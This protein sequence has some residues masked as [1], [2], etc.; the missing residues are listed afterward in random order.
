M[1]TLRPSGFFVLRTP[2]LPLDAYLEWSAGLRAPEADAADLEEALAADRALLV[3]R[4]RALAARPDVHD[5]LHLASPRLEAA[6]G[7]W[8]ESGADH[9]KLE[10]ALARYL[11]RMAGRA[12]PFGLFAGCSAGRLGAHARL[13]LDPR[14]DRSHARLGADYLVA[15]AGALGRD[16]ELRRELTYRP[17][18][19]RYEAAGRLRYVETGPSR[20]YH[21]VDVEPSEALTAVL[22]RARDGA[23]HRALA[24]SL[25]NGRTGVEEAAA[26]VDRL[27]DAQILVDDLTVAVTGE[28]A[29]H[30]LIR[31]LRGTRAGA[32]AAALLEGA[33]A[34]LAEADRA[35][36]GQRA[37]RA[38]ALRELLA[39]L[40]ARIDA[41][42]LVQVDLIR[43]A[44]G[45]ELP[46][47]VGEDLG[48][49]VGLLHRFARAGEPNEL[50]DLRRRFG[51]RYGDAAV[52]L[53]EA[54]DPE[55][56]LG[57]GDEGD[58]I[59]APAD[60]GAAD[61][62][63]ALLAR[64]ATS[65]AGR[66]G[67]VD[68][69]DWLDDVLALQPPAPLP[70]AL[71]A[72][73][74]L[75][76]ASAAALERGDYEL[77]LLGASGPSG[78]RLLG[79]FCH[80]DPELR[81]Q[82]ASHLREEEA[83]EP[84]AVFAEIAHLPEGRLGNIL[85]RPRLRE[86][87]IV[88]LAGSAAAPEQRI[89][90]ADLVLSLE[91]DLLV[92][93]SRRLG[94]RVLPRLTTAHNIFS[95]GLGL[96]R[97]LA[98][99]QLQHVTGG[100]AWDWG[101]MGGAE[102]LPRVRAGHVLLA[103]A[104][105]R[106]D[107]HRLPQLDA[108]TAAGRARAVRDWRGDLGV[109]RLVALE[110]GESSLPVDLENP[111]A[112]ELLLREA[113]AAG[114]AVVSEWWPEAGHNPV[115]GP[116]GRFVHEL[117]VPF[118]RARAVGAAPRQRPSL[119][120]VR[121]RRAA[122]GGEWLYVKLYTG[123]AGADRVLVEEVAPLAAAA[124][125]AGAASWHFVRYADPDVHLRVRVGGAREVLREAVLPRLLDLGERLVDSG[126]AWRV[127]HDTYEREVERYGGPAAIAAA[128]AA[129]RA[130]SDAVLA[131]LRAVSAGSDAA[132]A[133]RRLATA[134][135]AL[136]LRDLGL[137][138]E[139]ARAVAAASRDAL[140]AEPGAPA[141]GR[142]AL[143]RRLR[144]ERPALEAVLDAALGTGPAVDAGIAALRSRSQ[145]L[146]AVG[147]ELA[148]L[149]ARGALSAPLPVVAASLAHMHVNRLMRAD[150]R[151]HELYVHD[152]LERL[153]AG[154]RARARA[155][156]PA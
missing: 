149:D 100:I 84:D 95:R 82:V 147:R 119:E 5:A 148:A 129:F 3:E 50:T 92:L 20:S 63:D 155:V 74:V 40:P 112:V 78:A 52:P 151:R 93:R 53:T 80:A 130:D 96:Y 91:D 54:L 76:A 71:A 15:L 2:A 135:V 75:G 111:L 115:E 49:A 138:D 136:L 18:P 153:G 131:M 32:P 17:N 67:D 29:A 145:P 90:P 1:G 36:A 22:E 65:R 133:R 99:L 68:L 61:E 144:A 116:G 47:G 12:T 156:L 98:M 77:R 6:I 41:A 88:L 39:P 105:W 120:A 123:A 152:A 46:A 23:S 59:P 70:N 121:G 35:P 124:I 110:H 83:L 113:R 140:L 8:L 55:T 25:V 122:P 150:P 132:D 19:W 108:P 126:R 114:G 72:M 85:A 27:I 10:A 137:D 13:E 94:R 30:P 128:E 60:R 102:R 118:T 66:A 106:I 11:A 21:L 56:G 134:G 62:V 69:A 73:A 97:F 58:A 154:R 43:G 28:E 81:E 139:Q 104:R 51:E 141:G 117:V 125:A 24:E 34:A 103:P 142:S 87:E 31:R 146:Q 33:V 86:H 26:F 16:P 44:D 45:L 14:G 107:A 7:G 143:A 89:E 64:I 101:V 4:L 42:R 57:F 109:P 127:S 9:P 79:R 38:E 48:V 37:A